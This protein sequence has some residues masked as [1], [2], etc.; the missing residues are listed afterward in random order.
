MLLHDMMLNGGRGPL[1]LS[2]LASG[3][4]ATNLTTYTFNDVSFGDPASDRLLIISATWG[5]FSGSR[6]V[7][8]ATIGGVAATVATQN[9]GTNTGGAIAYAVV[10]SGSTGTVSI[11]LNTSASRLGFFIHRLVNY[12]SSTPTGTNAPAGG[13]LGSRSVTLTNPAGGVSLAF[14][15][16]GESVG[17]WTNATEDAN[18]I[19]SSFGMGIARFSSAT[20]VVGRIITNSSCRGIVGAAW[21]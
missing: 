4:N 10:P 11:T 13:G 3:Y 18:R 21:N 12:K 14:A 1:S 2:Y 15:Y 8:S 6:D 5:L 16:A 19:E 20:E 9:D 17:T 7:S